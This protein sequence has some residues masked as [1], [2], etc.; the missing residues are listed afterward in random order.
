MLSRKTDPLS[1]TVGG[2]TVVRMADGLSELYQDLLTGNYD[3]VD[4]IVLN[5]YFRPGHHPGGF[6]VWW[7]KLTGSEET[8]DNAHLM[9][10]ADL[11]AALAH[12]YVDAHPPAALDFDPP[13]F[14]E[15]V[16]AAARLY[17][18]VS[19]QDGA[20]EK[21]EA[22]QKLEGFIAFTLRVD[23]DRFTP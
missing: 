6:R 15:L 11:Y 3:C 14:E 13:H 18:S 2:C 17:G 7:Q 23:R 16:D 22:G 1:A 20:P 19:N 9:R 12:E 21:L 5:A 10:L 4:R 8:L